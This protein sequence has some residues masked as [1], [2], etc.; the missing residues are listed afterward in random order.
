MFTPFAF[1]KQ[2]AAPGSLYLPLTT[3]FIAAAG[4]TGSTIPNALN[5]FEQGYNTYFGSGSF[6]AIYPMVGGTA[7]TMKYNFLDTNMYQLQYTGSI[8]YDM[9]GLTGNGSSGI[10]TTQIPA[11][12]LNPTGGFSAIYVRTNSAPGSGQANYPREM[13]VQGDITPPGGTLTQYYMQIRGLNGA[14]LVFSRNNATGGQGSVNGANSDARGMW[15]LTRTGR[16][17]LKAFDSNTQ[18]GATQTT[19]LEGQSFRTFTSYI[20]LLAASGAWSNRNVC[21]FAQGIGPSQSLSDAN[22][23]I[24]YNMTQALQ[25]S[26][27]RQI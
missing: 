6:T 13:G 18:F 23:T 22:A 1:V 7:D 17:S 10:A 8:T 26:M 21:F 3:A 24:F 2:D 20:T 15:V 12:Q 4:I 27:S 19:Q 16:T 9:N 14:E 25:T 11:N 5:A